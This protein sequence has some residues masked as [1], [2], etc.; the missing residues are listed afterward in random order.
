MLNQPGVGTLMNDTVYTQI[1]PWMAR[2]VKAYQ[3]L[4]REAWRKDING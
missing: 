2:V 3:E 1:V 4:D